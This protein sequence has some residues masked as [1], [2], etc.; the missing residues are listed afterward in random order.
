MRVVVGAPEWW[1]HTSGGDGLV[2]KVENHGGRL[3][4]AIVLDRPVGFLFFFIIF[5][6]SLSSTHSRGFP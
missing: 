1:W 6:K 5:V 2:L 3:V 4:G